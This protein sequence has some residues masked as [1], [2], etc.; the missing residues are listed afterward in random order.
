MRI[1]L[2]IL[3][4]N[5][6]PSNAARVASDSVLVV[7][8]SG[9]V[10]GSTVRWL[11]RLS[12]AS[13]GAPLQI[14]IGGRSQQS[15]ERTSAR[16]GIDGLS[17]ANAG[18]PYCDVC[19]E[20]VLSRNSK[21]LA[22]KASAKGVPAVVSCGIWPGVSA[23]MAAEAVAKL[24][25]KGAC[26]R[27]EFSFFTAGTGGAGP[28]IVS[29][30]FLLLA[31]EVAAYVD[32]ELRALEPWTDRV[33]RDF[34]SGVGEHEAFLLDN[35]DVPTTAEALGIRTCSSRFGTYPTVWN[36]LFGAMKALPK[37]LL[38]DRAK[39]QGLALFSMPIIR[40]VDAL[41]G[42][43][44]AMRVDA[45]GVDGRQ[46]TLRVAHSDLEDCVGQATAAFG[47][48]LLRRR[49]GGP[50]NGDAT[51]SATIGPGVWYPAELGADA[52]ANILRVAREKAF[53][54]EL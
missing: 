32:G 21:A 35:P 29:A 48:E 28:T 12:S 7:G 2:A 39:M 41:V 45:W 11:D 50:S 26:E 14:A 36:G 16:L 4:L 31:T 44:N 52:R 13:G 20:L 6:L 47:M 5:S 46:V 49:S 24:G 33:V 40:T 54:W 8:G 30:T 27:L 43:T 17:F 15:F 3:V 25:G 9:R 51:I 23:L 22:A 10:G 34:G 37:P 38:A 18:V 1:I 42:G 53:V 19:D